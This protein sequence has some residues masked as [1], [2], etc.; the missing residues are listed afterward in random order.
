MQ[1]FSDREAMVH[2]SSGLR[3]RDQRSIWFDIVATRTDNGLIKEADQ[4]LVTTCWEPATAAGQTFRNQSTMSMII[5]KLRHARFLNRIVSY[6][7]PDLPLLDL[8]PQVL[9]NKTQI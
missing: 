5:Y 6:V 3:W 9:H 4:M 2:P 7:Q 1:K 8:S